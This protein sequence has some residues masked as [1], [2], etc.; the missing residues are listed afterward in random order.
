MS[1]LNPRGG[2]DMLPHRKA[3]LLMFVVIAIF[4]CLPGCAQKNSSTGDE[5][6]SVVQKDKDRT[7]S[8]SL[9]KGKQPKVTFI[10]LGSVKC[11][12]C[13]MMQEI[14]K[15]IEQEYGDQVEILFYDVWTQEGEPYARKYGIRVIPTQVFLDSDGR[16]Y[17]RHEGY[18][19]KVE[20]VKVLKQK[21][22]K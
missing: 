14:L 18:F 22:V 2:I 6:T 8:S 21:G 15:E 11:I 13:I 3:V 10:E 16:E 5:E 19:P 7:G 12:P 17:F 20:L 4:T 9:S 1:E